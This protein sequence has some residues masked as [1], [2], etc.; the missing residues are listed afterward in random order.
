MKLALEYFYTENSD[1]DFHLIL[2]FLQFTMNNSLNA[3]I[4]L[5][6]NQIVYDFNFTNILNLLTKLSTKNITRLCKIFRSEAEKSMTWVNVI[7]KIYYDDKHSAIQ[8][9]VANQTYLRLHYDYII[10]ELEN[11]TLS[12]QRVNSFEIIKK[13]D[14]LTYKLK[15]SFTMFIH[16]II[17]VAQLKF[18]SKKKD[19]YNRSR[20]RNLFFV[21]TQNFKTSFY[22]IERILNKQIVRNQSSYLIKW[23]RYN[24][25]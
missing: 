22:E 16:S 8:L 15:L 17:S 21:T 10:L 19:S 6:S 7:A 25:S 23:K 3:F 4:D 18:Y 11:K 2:L 12:N 20:S 24:D 1:H 13:I 14:S 9:D 5:F